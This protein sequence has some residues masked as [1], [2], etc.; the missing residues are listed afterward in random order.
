MLLMRCK[1]KNG[2]VRMNGAILFDKVA[3]RTG[4][5]KNYL[6]HPLQEQLRLGIRLLLVHQ[7]V[8]HGA[9]P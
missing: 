4:Q 5:I 3:L 9:L 1:R 2:H 7:L 6:Q 8:L